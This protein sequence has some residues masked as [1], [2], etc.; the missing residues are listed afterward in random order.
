MGDGMTHVWP[1]ERPTIEV[2][3][4]LDLER[5]AGAFRNKS[6]PIPY[7]LF[8]PKLLFSHQV[9]SGSLRLQHARLPCPSPSP[10]VYPSSWPLHR[11]CH[12]IISSS[13]PS[14]FYLSQHQ[15]L[16]QWVSSSHGQS[17]EASA[18]VVPKSIRGWLPLRLIGLISLLSKGL[19]RVFSNTTVRKHQFFDTLPSLWSN[20]H[21]HSWLLGKTKQNKA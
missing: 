14:A 1:G 6:F 11:W 5:W 10:R 2:V 20:S 13:S 18:S 15:G 16:F 21:I 3:P 19:S 7:W 9:V 12:P 8:S 17:T 4:E